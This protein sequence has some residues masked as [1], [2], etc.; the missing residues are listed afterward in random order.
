MSV[1]SRGADNLYNAGNN[2][3]RGGV[4]SVLSNSFQ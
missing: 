2:I 4:E 3:E 1:A